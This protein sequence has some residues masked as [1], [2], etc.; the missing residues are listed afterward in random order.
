MVQS[1]SWEAVYFNTEEQKT[2]DT[3]QS[4]KGL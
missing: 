2:S 3:Q 4:F 1:P